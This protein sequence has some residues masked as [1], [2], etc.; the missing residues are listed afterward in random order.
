MT[1]IGDIVGKGNCF[2]DVGCN[3]GVYTY[4]FS[5]FFREVKSF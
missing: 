4:H 5:R 3:L 2:V 1:V